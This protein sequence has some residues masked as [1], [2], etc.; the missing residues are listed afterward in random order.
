MSAPQE[1]L[2]RA[3]PAQDILAE[4][5]TV[6]RD[7]GALYDLALYDEATF[8][9]SNDTLALG[10]WKLPLP[11]QRAGKLVAVHTDK[12]TVTQAGGVGKILAMNGSAPEQ[13]ESLTEV[14]QAPS[15]EATKALYFMEQRANRVDIYLYFPAATTAPVDEPGGDQPGGDAGA[16]DPTPADSSLLLPALLGI[17]II[18]VV[19]AALWAVAKRKR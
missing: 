9:A 13:A 2:L 17:G 3:F 18:A 12:L 7:D 5:W 16:S 1:A 10:D 8:G 15:D 4:Y 11:E 14:L 19:G 6:S